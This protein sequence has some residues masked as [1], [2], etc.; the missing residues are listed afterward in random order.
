MHDEIQSNRVNLMAQ[1]LRDTRLP[2]SQIAVMLGCSD[3][4]NIS[5]FFKKQKGMSP[6]EYRKEFA[7]K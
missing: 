7:P 6:S 2:V 4:S 3:G 5:R 1:M